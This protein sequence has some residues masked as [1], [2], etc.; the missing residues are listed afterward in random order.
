MKI[1]A[2][3]VWIGGE[4]ELRS[5]T[6]V[7]DFHDKMANLI[8]ISKI[9][10]WDYDG[11]STKQADGKTSEVI[12]KPCALFR[13]PFRGENDLLVLCATYRPNG[14]PLPNN[15]RFHAAEIFEYKPDQ[16]PWF[17]LEQEYF[18]MVNNTHLPL[19]FPTTN[20]QQGQYYCSVGSRNAFGREIAEEHLHA[21]LKA[22]ITISGINAEVAPG[23]WEYQVGPCTGISAGDHLWM[24]RYIME[25]ITEKYGVYVSLDPKPLKGDWNG[26]GCHTNFSTAAMRKEGGLTEIYKSIQLLEEKHLEHMQVYGEDNNLRL[27]GLHET[28]GYYKFTSGVADRG[29]SVRIGNKTVNDGRGYFE[30]RRP[31]ANMDPY[32]VTGK[33]YE[34]LK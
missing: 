22:G 27:T 21:C 15:F 3:Y 33:I 30:D 11:S 4:G 32:L 7:L 14:T 9:P 1:L 13:D 25:R 2:E 8:T 16:A 24:A 28:S 6:R 29:A 17:G 20:K 19:G 5:K 34:T 23:Q 18:L 10:D 31:A 26:S 12:L